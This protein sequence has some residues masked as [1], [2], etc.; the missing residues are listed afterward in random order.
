M[1]IDQGQYVRNRS[2]LSDRL[3]RYV[4]AVFLLH[5]RDDPQPVEGVDSERFERGHLGDPLDRKLGDVGDDL[6]DL[7]A[8]LRSVRHECH[9][10]PTAWPATPGVE[11]CP[12]DVRFE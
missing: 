4:D 3:V 6:E 11:A 8:S 10:P 9:S 7:A 2:N 12:V 1:R 5:F